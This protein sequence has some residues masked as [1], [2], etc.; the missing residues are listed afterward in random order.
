MGIEL[1]SSLLN[2]LSGSTMLYYI[3]DGQYFYPI[4]TILKHQRLDSFTF[5]KVQWEDGNVTWEPLDNL[6]KA[7]TAIKDYLWRQLLTDNLLPPEWWT[8]ENN[9]DN[10]T[11]ESTS[12][13]ELPINLGI[14]SL[15]NL[16]YRLGLTRSRSGMRSNTS[17]S[18]A[19]SLGTIHLGRTSSGTTSMR[20]L[21]SR[22]QQQDDQ[23]YTTSVCPSIA[24]DSQSLRE[25]TT[26]ESAIHSLRF[27]DGKSTTPRTE[28][29][30]LSI[31]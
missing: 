12:S 17:S 13:Q 11:S 26:L 25:A 9:Q 4:S 24:E 7:Q 14:S 1:R 8:G 3:V 27:E 21:S 23:S 29:K 19:S 2:L 28:R 10:G 16:S 22:R 6:L 30:S 31:W 18:E 5:F 20:L 15:L